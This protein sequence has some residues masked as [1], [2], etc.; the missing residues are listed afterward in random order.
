MKKKL[1]ALLMGSLFVLAAC[2]GGEE[3]SD[4]STTASGGDAEKLYGQKCS[5]CHGGNLE[6]GVGPKLDAIGASLSKEDI[7]N[8]IANGQ[9]A[10]PKGLLQGED[11]STVAEWLAGKK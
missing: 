10:M 9:G 7:E 1:L 2:G 4:D 5:S 6:G 8:V 3:A 11:A